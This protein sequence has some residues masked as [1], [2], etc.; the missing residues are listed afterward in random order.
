M[1]LPSRIAKRLIAPALLVAA[2]VA[3]QV[4]FAAPPQPSFTVSAQQAGGCGT[5]TFTDTSTDGDIV[6]DLQSVTWDFG[7]GSGPVTGLPGSSVDHTFTTANPAQR[8]VTL[9]ATDADTDAVDPT[10][11][12]DSVSTSQGVTITHAPPT[13]TF[14]EPADVLLGQTLTITGTGGGTGGTYVWDDD[15]ADTTFD[16]AATAALTLNYAAATATPGLKSVALRATDNCGVTS[17]NENRSF[18]NVVNPP[19]HASFQLASNAISAGQPVQITSTS[20]DQTGG[21]IASYQWD[22]N[23]NGVYN[24]G[25]ATGEVNAATVTTTFTSGFAPIRL[26]VTDNNGATDDEVGGVAVS[27]LPL[28]TAGFRWSPANPLPGQRITLTSISRASTAANAPALARVQWDFDYS[29]SRGFVPDATGNSVTH[30]FGTAGAK[31]VAIRAIDAANG[32]STTPDTIVVNAP[33]SAS[34][35]TSPGKPTE[36]REVTFASTATDPDGPLVKQE[37]DL[38]GDSRYDDAQGAVATTTKLKRGKR[39]VRLRV[40]DSKG[41]TS[42]VVKSIQVRARPLKAPVDVKRSLGYI[43]EPWG[44]KL[45]ALIVRVPSKTA[46]TVSCKGRGCPSQKMRKRSRKRAATLTFAFVKRSVRAGA[47]L[48][49]VTTR[50]GHTPAYDVYT[51]RGHNQ[52]PALKEGCKP[53]GAKQQRPLS[54]C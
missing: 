3:A 37:W 1:N 48:T 32:S 41:A 21:S 40:T 38:D 24:E 4:V 27:A 42:S 39:T 17:V 7:D 34:F 54:R 12:P 30:S 53:P 13:A 43:R 23:N 46:V 31:T 20:T 2:L 44:A 33:P 47:K 5:F 29:A 26:I 11:G 10:D 36:G 22:L 45:V 6:P 14:P 25:G 19:P 50:A 51:I 8:T 15:D 35:T 49:V 9:T 16:D 18:Y 28:P 52:S